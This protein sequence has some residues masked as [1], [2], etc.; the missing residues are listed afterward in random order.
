MQRVLFHHDASPASRS[1]LSALAECGLRVTIVPAADRAGLERAL[2]DTEVLWHVLV[3]VTAE[4]IDRAPRLVL[5]QKIGVGVNTIDL[6]A[7]RARGIAVC[8]MPGTNSRAVA[9]LA[10]GLM[11]AVLRRIPVLDRAT[12]AGRGWALPDAL[13]DRFGELA[14]RRVGLLGMGAVP[15]LLAPVL[16]AMG[17]EAVYWSR[18]AKPDAPARYMPLDEL[19]ATSEVVSLHLPLVPDTRRL[20]S[21]ERIARMKPGAIL[22]NTARG[23]LVDEAALVAALTRG[24]L[25]GAGLDVFEQEPLP[26]DHPLLA[27]EQVVVTPHLAWLTPETLERSFAVAVE[28][29]RRLRA[30]EPLLHRVA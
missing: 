23:A 14:G 1:R 7:C 2:P 29:C 19:L 11:L 17:A 21:A 26:S 28:N 10:L 20:L 15:R 4:M 9:E 30:G 27:L 24:H 13:A 25:A 8:N 18:T 3:P 5:V 16:T 12:R 6:E 22:I